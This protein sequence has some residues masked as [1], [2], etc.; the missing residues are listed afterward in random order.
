MRCV[1]NGKGN[2]ISKINKIYCRKIGTDWIKREKLT[3]VVDKV[4]KYL[5]KKHYYVMGAGTFKRKFMVEEENKIVNGRIGITIRE[6]NE[7]PHVTYHRFQI[8]YPSF[9]DS[10]FGL[11][12]LIE[13]RIGHTKS[14]LVDKVVNDILKIHPLIK[15]HK[16]DKVKIY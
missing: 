1:S 4:R 15:E 8:M 9:S 3:E 2:M 12:Y 7:D 11:D 6:H 13:L 5:E 10:H 16:K 14:R